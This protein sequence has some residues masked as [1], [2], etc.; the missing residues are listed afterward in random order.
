MAVVQLIPHNIFS[1]AP[2]PP[3]PHI[4]NINSTIRPISPINKSTPSPKKKHN[5]LPPPHRKKYQ[6]QWFNLCLTIYFQLHHPPPKKNHIYNNLKPSP[7]DRHYKNQLPANT[8]I[9]PSQYLFNPTSPQKNHNTPPPPKKCQRHGSSSSSTY[10]SR[11]IF[12][13]PIPLKK[14]IYILDNQCYPYI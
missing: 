14:Y 5:T 2:P 8:S 3:P 6:R 12:N 9:L 1:T 4:Y 13:C 7:L 10:S 11:Y